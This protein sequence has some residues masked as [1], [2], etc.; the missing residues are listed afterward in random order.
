MKC[1]KISKSLPDSK[2]VEFS[3]I[4]LTVPPAIDKLLSSQILH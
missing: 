1:Q 2:E 3:K 4:T